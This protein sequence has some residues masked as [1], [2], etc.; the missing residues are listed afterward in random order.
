MTIYS[1]AGG[2]VEEF[3]D[4]YHCS[5]VDL[6]AYH[7][8]DDGVITTPATCGKDGVK[9]YT[10]VYCG[11]TRTE[12]VPATGA[13]RYGGVVTTPATCETAGEKIFT[14]A[15]CGGHY[16]EPISATGHDWSDWLVT[17]NPSET[18]EGEAYRFCKNN[19]SILSIRRSK[20][21][22]RQTRATR[23][24]A[25]ASANGS[26]PSSTGSAKRSACCFRGELENRGRKREDRKQ[27]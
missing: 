21:C 10:C 5:F 25:S 11:G 22:R 23:R 14:C 17:R 7:E 20:S 24:S 12:P 9:T 3:A 19:P 18:R 15:G 8:Y 16:V 13:H 6:A 1:Y 27:K 4:K 2:R 26:S